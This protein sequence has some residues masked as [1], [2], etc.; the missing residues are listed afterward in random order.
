MG[1][2]DDVR[3]LGHLRDVVNEDRTLLLESG[4]NVDVVH[5]LFAHVNGCTE[6]GEGFFHRDHRTIHT[7]AISTRCGQ[8]HPLGSDARG[9]LE[10]TAA[11]GH[12]RCV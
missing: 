4:D 3:T 9:I 2:K 6:V 12:T 8:Q 7:R 5:N 11:G 10:P 1:T